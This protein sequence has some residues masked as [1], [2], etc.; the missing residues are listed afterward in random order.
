MLRPPSLRGMMTMS[1]E[2]KRVPAKAMHKS[3]WN[4][5]VFAHSCY[6]YERLQGTGF[7]YAMCPIID[8]LYAKDDVE[9]RRKAMQRHTAFFNTE[10]RLGGA[11]VGL[12]AAMEERIAAGEIELADDLMPSVKY[13][14]MGPIAGVGDT[15]IQ[16]VLSPILL[17]LCIG[18]AMDGNVTGPLLYLAMFV[19][20]LVVMGRHSFQ[21]GYKKGDEAIMGLL[22]SGLINKLITAA[23]I[24]GCTVMGALVANYVSLSTTINL[25]LTTGAF[26]L[27]ADVFDAIMPKALPLA[28]ALFVY[29]LMD[30]RGV[31]ALRMMAYLIF[32]GIVLGYLG[33]V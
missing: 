10:V 6:N 12:T 19:A 11:I 16:A 3:F 13:G 31:S 5:L 7:L 21:L 27:Q 1:D 9:G 20:L 29:W 30:K 2:I 8:A 33:I 15:I 22:E 24:M 26:D 23:G 14:L 28:L 18:L 17:S 32:G 25:E 4:W